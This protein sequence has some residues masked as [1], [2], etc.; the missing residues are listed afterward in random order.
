MRPLTMRPGSATRRRM[1]I[2]VTDLP[3]PDSPTMPIVSP[4]FTSKLTPSTALTTAP[5]VKKCVFRSWT[6]RSG[7]ASLPPHPRV[8]RVSQPVTECVEG[9]QRQAKGDRGN[10]RYVRGIL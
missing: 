6:C 8:Q 10:Q 1:D 9:D 7:V 2:D 3:L 4:R 5:E